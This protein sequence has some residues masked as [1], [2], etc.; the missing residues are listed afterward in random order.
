MP[1]PKR[2]PK[3][4][5]RVAA[6]RLKP[7]LFDLLEQYRYANVH[8]YRSSA[9]RGI[10]EQELL[11]W[12]TTNGVTTTHGPGIQDEP[13]PFPGD[14]MA[15]SKELLETGEVVGIEHLE[16][17]SSTLEPSV[18]SVSSVPVPTA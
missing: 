2:A 14:P 3:T 12:A 10:L 1:K 18:S 8:R 17:A 7:A 11:T 5:M 13:L 4:P 9:I 15:E 16:L 6:I